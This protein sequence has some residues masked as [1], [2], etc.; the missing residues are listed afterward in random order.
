MLKKIIL[1]S[2]GL[3]LIIFIS[4]F[5]Y[6]LGSLTNV[7]YDNALLNSKIKEVNE[8]INTVKD[9]IINDDNSLKALK[10]ENAE[11]IKEFEIWKNLKE[12][13]NQSL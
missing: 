10:E 12:K 9:N 13:I 3:F 8:K 4:S 11:K 7:R 6:I 5:I 1:I 2:G